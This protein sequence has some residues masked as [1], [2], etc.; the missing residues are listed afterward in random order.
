MRV[1]TRLGQQSGV[2]GKVK[3]IENNCKQIVNNKSI[4]SS[5]VNLKLAMYSMQ[6]LKDT[7]VF[8]KNL[9]YLGYKW[10]I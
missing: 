2:Q 8:Y 1:F 5:I 3:A 4:L 9:I 6:Q 7:N 10:Q